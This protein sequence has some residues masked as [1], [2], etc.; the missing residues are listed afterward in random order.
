[1]DLVDFK[2]RSIYAADH[3][4]ENFHA[5]ISVAFSA[6]ATKRRGLKREFNP[7]L[8]ISVIAVIWRATDVALEILFMLG[9]AL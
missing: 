8:E 9:A 2:L 4:S 5:I 7:A 3:F 1:L 6:I